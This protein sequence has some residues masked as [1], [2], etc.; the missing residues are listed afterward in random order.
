MSL[1]CKQCL[2]CLKC[3]GIAGALLGLDDVH[4]A[5]HADI[6]MQLLRTVIDVDQKQVI[7]Q[8]VL[9]EVVLI[10]LLLVRNQQG[11]DLESGELADHVHVVAV[12]HRDQHILKLV[13]VENL[14]ELIS[15]DS[16]AV[17]L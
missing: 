6:D 7:E 16:L 11:L 4:Y 5:L 12:A 15:A 8:E 10:E 14:K 3:P 2:Q 1:R 17:C 9:D 13:L